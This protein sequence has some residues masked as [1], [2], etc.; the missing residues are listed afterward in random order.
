[1]TQTLLE[2]EDLTVRFGGHVAVDAVSCGFRAG[3]L[4]AIVGYYTLVAYTLNVSRI[5]AS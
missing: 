1:M 4:T 3:E 5:P 2:T